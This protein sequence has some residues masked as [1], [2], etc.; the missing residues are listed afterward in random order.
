MNE[1]SEPQDT[2][3]DQSM[4]QTV[5]D[6][7]AASVLIIDDDVV[8]LEIITLMLESLGVKADTA[9]NGEHALVLI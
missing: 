4:N 8:N 3:S 1:V 5:L 7:N 2:G 9:L 6:V